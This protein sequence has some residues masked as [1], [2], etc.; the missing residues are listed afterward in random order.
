[1][2]YLLD[3]KNKRRKYIQATVLALVLFAVFY[4][5][6]PIFRALSYGT[7]GIFRPVMGA[8]GGVRG[9]FSSIGTALRFKSSLSDENEDLKLKQR[10]SEAKILNHNALLGEN[11]NLKE[12]LGRK[13]E[14]TNL[15]LG[16][17]LGRPNRS[18]YDTFIL[19]V[20]TGDG[21]RN[22]D[23]VF[24]L[25]SVPVGRIVEANPD[26]SK[27]ILFS[28]S[29]TKTEVV[30][31]GSNAYFEIIGRGGG[32]FEMIL[33]RDFVLQKN[34]AV[35]LPGIYPYVV[36]VVESIISDPRDSFTK[37]LLVSPVNIQELKFVQVDIR[38]P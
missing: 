30:A 36:G 28:K 22:G 10:E 13:R 16:A 11:E 32:N 4:F 23:M 24:A 17:V 15:V 33:P 3:R 18:L 9:A 5:R 1:M 2:S 37:A 19:D 31:P 20:G 8:A 34:E 25:G 38:Y 35:T 12:I 21:V 6:G 7:H 29:G 14:N 27:A 26:S